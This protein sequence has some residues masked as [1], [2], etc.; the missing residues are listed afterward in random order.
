MSS[1]R[2]RVLVVD[3]D[4][5]VL[6]AISRL[7]A[8]KH[9]VVGSVADGSEV[10]EVVQRLQPDVVV[11][12]LHLPNVDGFSLC[13]QITQGDP[14]IRVVVFTAEY[15][16]EVRRRAFEAGASAF[17]HKLDPGEALL[18]AVHGADDPRE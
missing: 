11:L 4:P 13:R 2:L 7:L 6:R 5:A 12:D 15:D 1:S 9:N 3:D 8:L 16:P 10:L 18:S 17:V 14:E